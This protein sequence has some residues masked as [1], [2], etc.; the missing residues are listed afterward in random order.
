MAY[1]I[2][3]SNKFVNDINSLNSI[4]QINPVDKEHSHSCNIQL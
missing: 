2:V 1:S 4:I 3:D